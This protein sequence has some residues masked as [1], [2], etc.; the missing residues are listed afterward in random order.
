M[1][2]IL[3]RQYWVFDLDGTLT[4]PVHDFAV[5]RQRLSVPEGLDILGYLS[6]LPEH[7]ARPL[8]EKLQEIEVGLLYRVEPAQGLLQLIR[9]LHERNARFGILTR[10]TREI[11]IKTLERLGV[12]EYFTEESILGRECA[13]PKPDPQG[14]FLL[15]EQWGAAPEDLVMMGDYVFDLQTGRNAGAA[16][17]HVDRTGSYSWPELTDIGVATLTEL[18]AMLAVQSCGPSMLLSI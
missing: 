1:D 15:S 10:N 17:I 4:L 12:L 9:I 14:L 3:C 18:H 8:Y 16:T 7:E 13:L 5:I 2:A 6:S 11:A